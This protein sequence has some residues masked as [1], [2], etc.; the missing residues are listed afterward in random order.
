MFCN[1]VKT[2]IDELLQLTEVLFVAQGLSFIK[3]RHV[4]TIDNDSVKLTI[5]CD[6][7]SA[8]ESNASSIEEV[9]KLMKAKLIVLLRR[10]NDRN[11]QVIQE[12]SDKLERLT[13]SQ[14]RIQ[15]YLNSAASQ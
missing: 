8:Y 6:G 2:Q 11:E 10:Q 9:I 12:L 5:N 3:K 4:I 7:G 13:L 15:T 1:T 14:E